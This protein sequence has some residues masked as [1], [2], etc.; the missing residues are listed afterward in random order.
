MRV[1]YQKYK[2]NSSELQLNGTIPKEIDKRTDHNSVTSLRTRI[3][4][5]MGIGGILPPA[6]LLCTIFNSMDIILFY[7]FFYNLSACIAVVVIYIRKA[8]KYINMP[9]R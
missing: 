4:M 7:M 5:E 9:M 2:N 3:E 1:T 8:L 6:I